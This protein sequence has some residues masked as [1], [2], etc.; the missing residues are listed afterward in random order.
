VV[1]AL[2]RKRKLGTDH[3]MAGQDWTDAENDLIIADYFAMLAL[4]VAGQPYNKSAHRRALHGHIDRSPGAIEF[5]HQNLSAVLIAFGLPWINGYKPMFNF[6]DS[7]ADA[8]GRYLARHGRPVFTPQEQPVLAEP[9]PLWIGTAPT[10]RNAPDPQETERLDA[11]AR[12]FDVAGQDAKHRALGREGERVA[13]AHERAVLTSAGRADLAQAVRWTAQEDG[14]G[15]G[16]DIASFTADGSPRHVEVKTTNGWDR[17]PFFIT[18]NELS[19]AELQ[20]DT[21]VLLRL[22]DFARTPKAFE[23]RPPLSRH[24]ALTAT[25]YQADFH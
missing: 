2:A 1:L 10:L 24:V 20:S 16:Y 21:W 12:K 7:L 18:R 3:G 23:L 19:V 25:A 22:Y 4:D 11:I 17:T 15:A 6:Q 13:L 14:D 8:V 9:P 5:K